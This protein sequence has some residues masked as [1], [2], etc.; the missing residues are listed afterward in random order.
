MN[1]HHHFCLWG[2][3]LHPAA[4]AECGQQPA[5]RAGEER[6]A[7]IEQVRA[8]EVLLFLAWILWVFYTLQQGLEGVVGRISGRSLLHTHA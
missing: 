7:I 3:A 6:L 5:V 1:R 8:L 4:H 2:E